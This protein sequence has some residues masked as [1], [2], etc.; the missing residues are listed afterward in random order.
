MRLQKNQL[1]PLD[2]Y[3]LSEKTGLTDLKKLVTDLGQRAE[4]PFKNELRYASELIGK[5]AEYYDDFYFF[6]NRIFLDIEK[7]FQLRKGA[8]F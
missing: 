3:L 8:M 1:N 4:T 2:G 7:Y 5:D 6:R